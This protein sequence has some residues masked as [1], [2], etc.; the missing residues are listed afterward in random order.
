LAESMHVVVVGA[1]AM[2][3]SV[4]WALLRRGHR[5]TVLEQAD[6][7][8]NER[9]SSVD[10]HRLIRHPYGAEEGYARMIDPAL[11][12]WES[13]WVDLGVSHFHRT[14]TL[15][16]PSPAHHAGDA[17]WSRSSLEVLDRIGVSYSELEGSDLVQRWPQLQCR[18]GE[19]T[20]YLE[21]GGV[22][23]ARPIVAGLAAWVKAHGGEVRLSVQVER[24]DP[25]RG[26]VRTLGGEWVVGER[27]V[28]AAGP[29]V[30]RL[31][32]A[33]VGR[34]TPSRQVVV[35]LDP[36]EA[37]RTLWS[38]APMILDIGDGDGIYLVPSV[39]GTGLKVGDHSFSLQGHPDVDREAGAAEC[40]AVLQRCARRLSRFEAYRIDRGCTCFYTV[41]PREHFIVEPIGSR[42]LVLTGFSGHGFK[43]G[44]LIGLRVAEV[45][46]DPDR[47]SSLGRWAAGR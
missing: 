37:H 9:G 7:V 14:G 46:F 24:V 10:E 13:L 33:L 18:P 26:A 8:P 25:D 5:V 29:W 22:L 34:V 45:L 1:G 3:L 42:G 32:P 11:A 35:Y 23:L 28:V 6:S 39:G 12:A 44:A 4:A 21:S 30:G 15:L 38:Q 19:R 43:F 17:S 20:I 40:E 47:F 31:L 16:F 27:V 2:G 36:P 41:E